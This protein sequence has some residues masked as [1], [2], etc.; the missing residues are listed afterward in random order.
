M[1]RTWDGVYFDG[2]SSQRHRVT[3]TVMST[4][5]QI[6]REDG[7]TLWWP[8][9]QIRQTQGS[10]AGEQVRLEKGGDLPEALV[11][12]DGE[13]LTTIHQVSPSAPSWFHN[14]TR[15]SARL[16]L[17]LL[18]GAGAIL[19][20]SALY[21]WGIP[22]L[23]D[24]VASRIPASW[25]E[26][27]GRE[28]VEHLAPP[29]KRC[30]DPVRTKVLDEIVSVLTAA[31]RETPYTFRIAVV[32]DS[33]INA[34]A[35]PGGY[36]VIFR[37][38]LEKTR[39]A[40]EL[41]GVL[42]HEIQH[43]VQRHATKALVRELST[44]ALIAVLSGDAEGMASLLKVA[45]TLGELQYSRQDER[46][47]DDEGMKMLQAARIDPAGMIRFFITLKKE[48]MEIPRS[49]QY[50]S[51]HP[52]TDDR[53]EHLQRLAAEARYTPVRLLPRYPWRDIGEICDARRTR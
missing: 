7:S 4:G 45:G 18:A 27:L 17:T 41:A 20:G 39:T 1:R 35:A 6:L 21:L 26:R 34:F 11:V 2:R 25:E 40:E 15:R 49:M 32:N 13:F 10:Y 5:L 23:S 3:I 36:I 43:I 9:D 44:T 53:I 37:G 38:L 28:A 19:L 12:T 29:K 16:T 33:L 30:T 48:G 8:Y 42:A 31:G 22:A 50:L 51:T 47:A 46:E 24:A 52:Q 14:P